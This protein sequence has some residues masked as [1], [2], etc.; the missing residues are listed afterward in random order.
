MSEV[1]ART[2]LDIDSLIQ[3]IKQ[4]ARERGW[5][6]EGMGEVVRDTPEP[7]NGWTIKTPLQRFAERREYVF[8]EFLAG[9]AEEC[10]T[11]AYWGILKRP[12]D[13]AGFQ[14]YLEFLKSGGSRVFMLTAML[15]SP[16][17]QKAGVKIAGVEWLRRHALFR[18]ERV[19][20]ILCRLMDIVSRPGLYMQMG[21][22]AVE[23]EIHDT[24]SQW[25]AELLGSQQVLRKDCQRA[26]EQTA[27]TLRAR[28]A[29]MGNSVEMQGIG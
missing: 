22:M 20:R 15:W 4:I 12:P 13:P 8:T 27:S 11:R 1:T 14:S 29:E 3:R 21:L 7:G 5:A 18:N 28:L 25:R 10:V 9:S 16:E 24:L 19:R 23:N 17:G 2:P 26:A 6:L